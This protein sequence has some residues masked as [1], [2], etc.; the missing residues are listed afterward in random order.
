[1]SLPLSSTKPAAEP[2]KKTTFLSLPLEIRQSIFYLSYD[3]Q[4][5]R[6]AQIN[7]PQSLHQGIAHSRRDCRKWA[8]NARLVEM[9]LVREIRSR[10]ADD[11]LEMAQWCRQVQ[12]THESFDGE[13]EWVEAKWAEELEKLEQKAKKELSECA[14]K[15]YDVKNWGTM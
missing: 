6:L 8:A 14:E 15:C 9:H 3:S 12:K 10:A 11:F 13:M 4:A 7:V 2:V 1:M 5:S